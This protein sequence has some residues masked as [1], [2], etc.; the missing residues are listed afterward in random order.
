MSQMLY[1]KA[2]SEAAKNIRTRPEKI[3][4]GLFH[5]LTIHQK[6][7]D[8]D[9]EQF[10]KDLDAARADGWCD[11]TTEASDEVGTLKKAIA[12]EKKKA[13]PK[14]KPAAKKKAPAKKAAK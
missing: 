13:A 4:G 11:T 8:E 2:G 10:E 9:G 12:K 5:H 7:D 3:H 14:K 6:T 1:K